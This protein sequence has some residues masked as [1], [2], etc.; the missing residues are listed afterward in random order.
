[1]K[2]KVILISNENEELKKEVYLCSAELNAMMKQVE[3]SDN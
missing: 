1:V 3:N 2:L